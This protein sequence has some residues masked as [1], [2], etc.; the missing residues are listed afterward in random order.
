MMN[1]RELTDGS[2]SDTLI[3]PDWTAPTG[4]RAFCTTRTPP[5]HSRSS[6]AN[7][8]PIDEQT[9]AYGSFNLAEHVGDDPTCV[10]L[11]RTHLRRTLALPAEPVWLR[12]VH[13]TD[14]LDDNAIDAAQA[15]S[16][17]TVA[18]A[19]GAVSVR[20]GRV[21]AIMTA[22]CVPLLMTDLSGSFAAAIH[23]GWRG[24][25][26]GIVTA[27]VESV[28]ERRP[29]GEALGHVTDRA[30]RSDL[31]DVLAWVGPG[32]SKRAFEVGAD[33]YERARSRHPAHADSFEPNPRGRWQ[34]DLASMIGRELEA[35][36]VL[37]VSYSRHCTFGE[38]ETLYSYRRDG[39]T[40]RMATL[41]WRA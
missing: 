17:T 9:S 22:D 1:E 7:S 15:S 24:L 29:A 36:G 14:V 38:P 23:V 20:H 18:E 40:G 2:A 30:R 27:A 21:L 34:C 5:G 16:S 13:G 4:I 10:S 11:N 28:R 37:R 8:S 35:S 39:V 33:V 32:I 19:D 41:I 6:P 25:V 3:I 12:Q 31:S 26:D